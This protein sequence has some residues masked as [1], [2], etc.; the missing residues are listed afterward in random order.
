LTHAPLRR[1]PRAAAAACAAG[2]AAATL[3]LVPSAQASPSGDAVVIS[4]VYGG[5][6]GTDPAY[7]NDFVELYN[8][9]DAA[10]DLAGMSVQY[11]SAGGEGP[12]NGTVPLTGTI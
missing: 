5:G 11:R 2:L 12:T 6:A 4:E 7:K 8:P 3:A 10:I 9:T 1:A